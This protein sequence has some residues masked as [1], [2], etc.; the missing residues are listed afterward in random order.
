MAAMAAC[1]TS[2]AGINGRSYIGQMR[3][4]DAAHGLVREPADAFELFREQQ[5]GVDGDAHA[6]A[7]ESESR[8]FEQAQLPSPKWGGAR[9]GD[10]T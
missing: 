10:F 4:R 5:A 8:R 6:G 3:T 1:C 9:G 7:K 2:L